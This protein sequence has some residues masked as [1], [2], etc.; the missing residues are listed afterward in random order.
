MEIVVAPFLLTIIIVPRHR[1]QCHW[2]V[3]RMP[4]AFCI[5]KMPLH[6]NDIYKKW[7]F[8]RSF[9]KNCD[10]PPSNLF[11]II[12]MTLCDGCTNTVPLIPLYHYIYTIGMFL[13]KKCGK[14]GQRGIKRLFLELK[15]MMQRNGKY[16]DDHTR[17]ICLVSLLRHFVMSAQTLYHCIYHRNCFCQIE[18]L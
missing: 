12:V 9:E 3:L 7:R 6:R 10:G 14:I 11:S 2:M 4:Q 16:Q 15:F 1:L 8:K 13:S 18:F 17:A 5:H